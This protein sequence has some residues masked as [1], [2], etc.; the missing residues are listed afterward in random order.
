MLEKRVRVVYLSPADRPFVAQYAEGLARVARSFQSWLADQTGGATILLS[1]P[2]V[3]EWHALPHPAEFYRSDPRES[4]AR[5]R[6]REELRQASE[7]SGGSLNPALRKQCDSS[8]FWDAVLKDAFALTGASFHDSDN[9]WVFNVDAEPLCGQTIGG[10]SGVALNGSNDLRGVAGQEMLPTCPGEPTANPGFDR[11]T[12]GFGHELG[13]ALG[14]PHP[15]DS[16]GGPDDNCLMYLGYATFPN[17]Y[18]RPEEI[19]ALA[20]TGFLYPA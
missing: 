15:D 3:V 8:R 1:E 6:R 10:A 18:L 7:A 20:A 17:T 9:R 16:P 5:R 14:L 12:G 11:W 19:A 4:R 13:H 2:D